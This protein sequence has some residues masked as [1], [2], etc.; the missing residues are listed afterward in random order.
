MVCD[1]LHT[2]PTKGHEDA[3]A[4]TATTVAIANSTCASLTDTSTGTTK[5]NAEPP[6]RTRCG[7]DDF[8]VGSW[9]L[10][11]LPCCPSRFICT[12]YSGRML[13]HYSVRMYTEHTPC[14]QTKP[15]RCQI[16][17]Q[18]CTNTALVACSCVLMMPRVHCCVYPP[19]WRREYTLNGVHR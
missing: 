5:H 19:L 14:A 17:A 3:V 2:T 13:E 12:G 11:F 4:T 8:D 9:L 15:L 10:A 18:M 16:D 1:S 6:M 7:W